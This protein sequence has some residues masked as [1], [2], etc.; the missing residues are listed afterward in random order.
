MVFTISP[1]AHSRDAASFSI[2]GATSWTA[3]QIAVVT[4]LAVLT[5]GALIVSVIGA[6]RTRRTTRAIEAELGVQRGRAASLERE[7]GRREAF[8]ERNILSGPEAFSAATPE[9]SEVYQKKSTRDA[10][11][12]DVFVVGSDEESDDDKAL[13]AI[14]VILDGSP[15]AFAPTPM[16]VVRVRPSE[17][18]TIT[19]RPRSVQS[20]KINPLDDDTAKLD[21]PLP[22][23]GHD[24]QE[25][26][27]GR[28]GENLQDQLDRYWKNNTP[29]M[30]LADELMLVD[31]GNL[32]EVDMSDAEADQ[33][34][35]K[36]AVDKGPGVL[37][38]ST[39]G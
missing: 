16:S 14:R 35:N 39:G 7:L 21:S 18:K 31:E 22:S 15:P 23:E 34:V 8:I 30:S 38:V 10:G 2:Q 36:K 5:V 1:I 9:N 17:I 13:R 27:K 33:E 24:F 28:P 32:S 4:M 11:H 3:V 26:H 29:G 20:S 37:P 12:H 6:S 25:G 19:V